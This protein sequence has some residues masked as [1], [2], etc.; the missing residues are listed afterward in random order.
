MLPSIFLKLIGGC[1]LIIG[2]YDTGVYWYALTKGE[3]TF[4][5]FGRSLP[6]N[7]KIV[8]IGFAA[9]LTFYYVVGLLLVVEG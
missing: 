7:H 3:E 1:L 6:A 2:V 8:R 5:F 4:N 9:V